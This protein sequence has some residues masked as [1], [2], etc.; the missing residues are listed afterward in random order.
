MEKSSVAFKLDNGQFAEFAAQVL[1]SL[2]RDLDA[3]TVQGWIENPSTLKNKL[4]WILL[5]PENA[6]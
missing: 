4:R 6:S 5:P 1:R 3:A 2:P